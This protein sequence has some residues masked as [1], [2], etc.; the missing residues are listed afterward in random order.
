V[1]TSQTAGESADDRR[2]VPRL[3]I[4]VRLGVPELL[5][6]LPLLLPVG[7]VVGFVRRAKRLGYPSVLAYLRAAPRTD[8]EKRDAVNLAM[9]GLV[10]ALLGVLFAPIVLIGLVPLFYGGRKL[11]YASLGLGL[12]DDADPPS[13]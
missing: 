8:E 5:I 11:A 1:Y 10:V 9:K 4:T 3:E 6:L 2:A 13:R 12:V 7:F